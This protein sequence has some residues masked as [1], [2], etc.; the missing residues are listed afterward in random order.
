MDFDAIV[1]F[2]HELLAVEQEHAVSCMLE[3]SAPAAPTTTQRRPLALALVIDRS[4]SMAGAKLDVARRCAAFLIERLGA[5]DRLAIVS[6]DEHVT[7]EAPLREVGVDRHALRSAALAIH[8]G[9]QT[10]LSGGWLKGVEALS[11]LDD[12]SH[13]RRVLLLT[14]GMA[15]VGI[16][17]DA[18][19][20]KMARGSA[21]DGIGTTT[22]GFGDGFSEDLL[23]AMADA[24]GGGA[25][26]A[27]SPDAAPAIFAAEFDDLLSVV[28][29]NVSAEIRPA[30]SEVELL[31]ILND[32]PQ[33]PVEGG[34][35]IQLGDAYGDERRRITFQLQVPGLP[36]LGATEIARVIVRYVSLGD[37]HVA[38]HE[39]SVPVI[40]NAVS[41]DDAASSVPDA[42]VTE[43][44][45]ILLGARAQDEARS[46]A[47]EGRFDEASAKLRAAANSLRTM[48]QGS[49]RSE[50]LLTEAKRLEYRGDEIAG[51][52]YDVMSRKHMTFENRL[53]KQRRQPPSGR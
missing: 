11:P 22:I 9:G 28:A 24:G 44:V 38:M 31:S 7:L 16:T 21:G 30:W 40:V 48:A 45:T 15:N 10:N 4:G 52:L 18:Q 36:T 50:E 43:E 29:Q 13:T 47:D 42:E 49:A 51:G 41:A 20:A 46:L 23:A 14:D 26:F 19:L 17:D 5:D 39:L 33:V 32:F 1:R 34:V 2:D 27:P 53:R 37:E 8:P 35:Q 3:L 12:G 6:F 25:H